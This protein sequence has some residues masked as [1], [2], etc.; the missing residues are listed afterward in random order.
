MATLVRNEPAVQT[1]KT[2]VVV[3]S[4]YAKFHT[5]GAGSVHALER[6]AIRTAVTAVGEAVRSILAL[7]Q[8]FSVVEK[9]E[10]G[11]LNSDLV[12]P[13]TEEMFRR[14]QALLLQPKYVPKPDSGPKTLAKPGYRN[15]YRLEDSFLRGGVRYL[16]FR[17]AERFSWIANRGSQAGKSFA[18]LDCISAKF[19]QQV[20]MSWLKPPA[21]ANVPSALRAGACQQAA[22]QFLSNLGLLNET[23]IPSTSFPSLEERD[24]DLRL[25]TWRAALAEV[26]RRTDPFDYKPAREVDPRFAP[27]DPRGER[28]V[29]VDLDWRVAVVSPI[30]RSLPLNFVGSDD[31]VLYRRRWVEERRDDRGG[32]KG[33][34]RIYA[35]LPIFVGLAEEAPL[36][37]LGQNPLL[38]WWRSRVNEFEPLPA[39]SGR[40]LKPKASVLVVALEYD[41]EL[42]PLKEDREQGVTVRRPSRFISAFFGENGRKVNWSLVKAFRSRYSER[43]AECTEAELHFATSREVAPVLTDRVLGIHFHPEPVVSWVLADRAGNVLEE[44]TLQGNEILSA[45]IAEKLRLE[46][47]QG[48]LRWVGAQKFGEELERRTYAVAHNILGLLRAKGAN[49]AME[50]IVWVEKRRGGKNA[51][52][53]FTLWN[54]SRLGTILEWLAAERESLAT[55]AHVSDYVLRYTCPKC[56]ACRKA[57][58]SEEAADTLRKGEAL[59]CRKCGFEG[60][61]PHDHQARLVARL[62]AER[63][64]ALVLAH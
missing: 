5:G 18:D 29:N 47:M 51:N 55:V 56:S 17:I 38:S 36:A 26:A 35:A 23:S 4:F 6:E 14:A 37:K 20:I 46:E 59:S 7:L 42:R 9:G 22:Q 30:P 49:L 52:L 45:A 48:E 58:Q 43:H 57:K 34:N 33:L 1:L 50:E 53:R 63:L 10:I 40:R 28:P 62:G 16:R 39:W 44:G 60:A 15:A 41:P 8:E 27:D 13:A 64:R 24:P 12:I 61:V 54:Y 25:T 2:R 11:V 31:V 3:R 32:P 19:F 21:L